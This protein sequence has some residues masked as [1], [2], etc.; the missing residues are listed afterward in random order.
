MIVGL[1]V[2]IAEVHRIEQ[3]IARYGQAF[4][5]R[6]FTAAEIEYCERHRHRFERYA[7]RF[8]VK[9][10]T[11]KA[12]GTGWANGVRWVDI[13]V[14]RLPSGQPTLALQG[15]TRKHAERLGMRRANVTI[16]HSGDIA[17]AQ[18]I[19]EG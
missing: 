6:V 13:E 12:L 9:E 8:A 3:A 14:A 16:T 4:L 19:L 2:D 18:V 17:L 5:S 10:A 11:M 1:G 15:A 7:A